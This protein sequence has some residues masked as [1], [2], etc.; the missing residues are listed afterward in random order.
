MDCGKTRQRQINYSFGQDSLG[1]HGCIGYAYRT[2]GG[3]ETISTKMQSFLRMSCWCVKMFFM[4]K[5]H[6]SVGRNGRIKVKIKGFTGQN[7]GIEIMCFYT[8]CVNLPNMCFT[9]TH[10]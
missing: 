9:R 8:L 7:L 4:K 5:A 2:G 6:V 10:Q 3:V 1:M